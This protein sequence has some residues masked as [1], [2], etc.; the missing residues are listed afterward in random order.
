MSNTENSN[1]TE[2]VSLGSELAKSPVSGF[3]YKNRGKKPKPQGYTGIRP[4]WKRKATHIT[5]P[6]EEGEAFRQSSPEEREEKLRKDGYEEV[7]PGT[8]RKVVK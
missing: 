1:K 7:R 8:W 4:Y 2:K 5:T 6:T 3:G